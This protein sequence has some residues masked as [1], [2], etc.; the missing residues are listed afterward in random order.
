VVVE[1]N[2]SAEDI[3]GDGAMV[4]IRCLLLLLLFCKVFR[5]RVIWGKSKLNNLQ[6]SIALGV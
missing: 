2:E 5:R 3:A 6:K 1:K 4:V